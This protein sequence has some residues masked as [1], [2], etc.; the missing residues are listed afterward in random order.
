MFAFTVL[1]CLHH[2]RLLNSG[3]ACK[4]VTGQEMREVEGAKHVAATVEMAPL[5][6][7]S[8]TNRGINA[9]EVA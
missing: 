5:M 3:I 7:P 9:F 4:L 8:S 6:P 2:I 1:H